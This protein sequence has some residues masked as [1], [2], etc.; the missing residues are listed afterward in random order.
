MGDIGSLDANNNNEFVQGT[1][2][3]EVSNIYLTKLQLQN[4]AKDKKV[5]N[6]TTS[7]SLTYGTDDMYTLDNGM[8]YVYLPEGTRTIGITVDNVTYSGQ[9][10]TDSQNL[11]GIQQLQQV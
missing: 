10:T 9:V 3:N 6:F 5:T 1:A 8:I 2:T 7:D 11:G 4:V